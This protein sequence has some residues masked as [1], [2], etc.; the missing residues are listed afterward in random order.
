MHEA[1]MLLLL[2]FPAESSED[3]YFQYPDAETVVLELIEPLGFAVEDPETGQPRLAVHHL[4]IHGDGEVVVSKFTKEDPFGYVSSTLTRSELDSLF[5]QLHAKGVLEF[6]PAQV[7]AAE[8]RHTGGAPL[9]ATGEHPGVLRINLSVI[10]PSRGSEARH[11]QR[12]L[13][14]ADIFHEAELLKSPSLTRFA[15]GL[16]LLRE[17]FLG[18]PPRP[19]R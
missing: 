18:V 4:R 12:A 2:A 14:T 8:L 7:H 10:E 17:R 3:V 5:G 19:D 16:Q 6:D 11:L 1:L 13:S 15:E 9:P